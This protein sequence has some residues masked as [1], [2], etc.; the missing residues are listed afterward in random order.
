MY[1]LYIRICIFYLGIHIYY[2]F[3]FVCLF[4]CSFF[5]RGCWMFAMKNVRKSITGAKV[6]TRTWLSPSCSFMAH[7]QHFLCDSRRYHPCPL[8]VIC[9]MRQPHVKGQIHRTTWLKMRMITGSRP[10]ATSDSECETQLVPAVSLSV[11]RGVNRRTGQWK[12]KAQ[13]Q[14]LREWTPQLITPNAL[15]VP[16]DGVM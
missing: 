11:S 15:S 7:P 12:H 5:R 4:V 3:L 13:N 6:L 16:L 2:I 10:S 9:Q 8:S 14:K 1:R